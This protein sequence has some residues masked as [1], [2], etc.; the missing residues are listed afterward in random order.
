MLSSPSSLLANIHCWTELIQSSPAK[1]GARL[2]VTGIGEELVAVSASIREASKLTY[3]KVHQ[4]LSVARDTNKMVPMKNSPFASSSC[5]LWPLLLW[6]YA[7]I[8]STQLFPLIFSFQYIIN[9]KHINDR[10][11]IIFLIQNLR[12]LMCILHL[13]HNTSQMIMCN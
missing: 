13:E 8:P 4:G 10:V 11:C 3:I 2:L 5:L 12:N 6:I 7:F 1:W 9:I